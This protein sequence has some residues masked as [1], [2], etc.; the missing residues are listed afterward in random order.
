MN[1]INLIQRLLCVR[2]PRVSK[3]P[4]FLP[5]RLAQPGEHFDS[6]R[7]SPVANLSANK[8]AHYTGKIKRKSKVMRTLDLVRVCWTKVGLLG[9]QQ[10][11]NPLLA[12]IVDGDRAEVELVAVHKH[13]DQRRLAEMSLNQGFGERIFDMFLQGSTERAG[14]V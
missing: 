1:D 8:V 7:P 2:S 14:A 6:P 13:F 3:G 12:L 11:A 5:H 4:G 10:I 9:Q